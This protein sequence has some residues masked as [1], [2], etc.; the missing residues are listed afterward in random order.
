MDVQMPVVPASTPSA[1]SSGASQTVSKST[2]N[3]AAPADSSFNQVLGGQLGQSPLSESADESGEV[4]SLAQLLQMLQSLTLPMQNVVQNADVNADTSSEEQA[5]PESLLQAMNSNADLA[6]QLMKDPAMKMWFEQ[7]QQLLSTFSTGQS[8][9]AFTLPTDASSQ[10]TNIVNLQAQNI[11]LTLT[12]LTKQQPD[13]PILQYL[14]QNLQQVVEPMLPQL[15]ASLN[16]ANTLSEQE[17][18]G[19]QAIE[20]TD[21]SVKD[22]VHKTNL[23][24]QH[25]RVSKAVIEPLIDPNT[26]TIVQPAKSKL[27]L[28]AIRNVM[29]APVVQPT[30]GSEVTLEPIDEL[31]TNSTETT[32]FAVPLSDLQKAQLASPPV[33]K[34]PVQTINAANFSEEM[35]E[36]VLKNMKITLGE[37]ISEAKLSLFPKNLGHV[38]VKI[39]MHQGQLIAE[40][41]ADSLAGRQML[42]SQLPQ[43]KQALQTQGLQVEKLEVTQNA[44]MQSSMFQDQRQQ[45]FTNQSQRQ[46][47]NRSGDYGTDDL[48]FDQKVENVVQTRTTVYGNSFDVIA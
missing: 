16:T 37:G 30:A 36:H 23:A 5:L 26:V 39:T 10:T 14:N 21:E 12:S 4:T 7:A 20:G 43:L 32:S 27:E 8:N 42:E 47:K 18:P 25:K 41:T 46:S 22:V 6:G 34:A 9:V 13:N 11:L 44:S 33:E 1:T 38:D 2:T 3:G 28:L 48:D 17:V 35:T 24:A 15:V 45:Q 19:L 31:P 40:F 29:N